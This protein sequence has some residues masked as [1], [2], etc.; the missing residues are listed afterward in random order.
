M[1]P[2][3]F[4]NG[5]QG[6]TGLQILSRLSARADLKLLT[7]PAE[8]RKNPQARAEAINRC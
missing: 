1:K 6:R 8:L 5:D 4:V 3:V 7:L 2:S